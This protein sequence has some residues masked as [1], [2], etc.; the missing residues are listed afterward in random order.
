VGAY[1]F[2]FVDPLFT[3]A[4]ADTR[5]VLTFAMMFAVGLLISDLTL[6]I[7]R[8]ERSASEREGRTAALYALS[9]RLTSASSEADAAAAL[10]E[11]VA[12]SF[13]CATE[14]ALAGPN[15]GLLVSG[16]GGPALPHDGGEDGVARWVLEHGRPAG[17][18]TD[19]LP[20]ARVVCV[21]LRSGPNVPGVLMLAPK[22]GR[23]LHVE[24][25]ALLEAFAQQ[26]ALAIERARLAEDAKAAALRAKTEEMRSS[27]LSAVS[28]DLRTPLA[29]I[30]GAATSLRDDASGVSEGQRRE[31]VDTICEEAERLE[32]LV[33][34]LLDMTRLEAGGVTLKR[35]WVPLEEVL[36]AALGRLEGKLRGREVSTALPDDLPLLS[37]DPVLL[38]QLLVNLLENAA[39]YTPQGSPIEVGARVEGGAV[40]VE[41]CDRGPGIPEGARDEIFQKFYRGSHVGISGVG[42]GLPICRGI[43]EAHGGTIEARD[44]AGGGAMFRVSLPLV[45]K[46]P[47]PPPDPE[48][49]TLVASVPP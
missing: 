39:K 21:P 12:S 31:L 19:T 43:A 33:G 16:R 5:H 45:G 23:A 47:P 18:G 44:R 6:R 46:P 28:H 30:T 41:V 32:R 11:H 42:L 4:V 29:V 22:L 26:G 27:L 40:I 17:L 25:E 20:G 2:F 36:G 1:D 37:V 48:A 10:A 49:A 34:N 24:D 38:E 13:Q 14:V 15:A 3:F 7:R 8:Q 35:E 9:R